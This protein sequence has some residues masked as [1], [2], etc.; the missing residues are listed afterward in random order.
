MRFR[1]GGSQSH[2]GDGIK[3]HDSCNEPKKEDRKLDL[4]FDGP[5]GEHKFRGTEK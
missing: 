2:F 1:D 4:K 3:G 5:C